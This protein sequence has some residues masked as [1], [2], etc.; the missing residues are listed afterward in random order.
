[1]NSWP[2]HTDATK[3]S[4]GSHQIVFRDIPRNTSKEDLEE[5]NIRKFKV[6]KKA[7][8]EYTLHEK[9]DL[10]ALRGGKVPLHTA[11]IPAAA[12]T[13]SGRGLPVEVL[14]LRKAGLRLAG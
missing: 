9:A 11:L 3:L 12:A 7:E 14:G 13:T 8:I 1:M 6:W 10:L 2:F 4:K 5:T